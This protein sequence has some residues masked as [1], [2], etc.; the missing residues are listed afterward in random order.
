MER[1]FGFVLEQRLA[2]KSCP[3]GRSCARVRFD[4]G[5]ALA[6]PAPVGGDA[7]RVWTV[8]ELYYEFAGPSVLDVFCAACGET[9]PHREQTRLWTEPNVL[10]L[11]VRRSNR[12]NGSVSRHMVQPETILTLPGLSGRYELAA[13]IYRRGHR[14]S[15]GHFYCVCNVGGRGWFRFDDAGV[16]LFRGD[17]ERSELR[18]VYMLVYTR[19]R[20]ITSFAFVGPLRSVCPIAETRAQEP[21]PR[22]SVEAAR[23]DGAGVIQVLRT[24]RRARR[25][26]G[27]E[28][29]SIYMPLLSL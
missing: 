17:V 14:V 9:K 13:V 3:K 10:L 23:P 4:S 6:L 11:H 24:S 25:L 16:P 29:L 21:V 15:A 28:Y 18:F 20:G 19:R 7:N 5:R 12:E 22:G 1:L 8:T 26:S 27:S 2:C